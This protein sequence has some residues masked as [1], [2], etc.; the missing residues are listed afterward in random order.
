M[1]AR[2]GEPV[3]QADPTSLGVAERARERVGEVE[4]E[5]PGDADRRRLDRPDVTGC[6]FA[7]VGRRGIDGGAVEPCRLILVDGHAGIG[8]ARIRTRVGTPGPHR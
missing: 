5:R 6:A 2:T 7:P 8:S 3:S 4:V 1:I